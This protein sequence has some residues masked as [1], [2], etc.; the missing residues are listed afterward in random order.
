MHL[1]KNHGFPWGILVISFVFK[2]N[3]VYN[4]TAKFLHLPSERIQITCS[5][6]YA[7]HKQKGD[8]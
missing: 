3:G 4:Q 8:S 6:T 7:Y 1:T 5:F 2:G